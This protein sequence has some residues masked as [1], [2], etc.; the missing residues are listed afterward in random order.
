[1]TAAAVAPAAPQI[2]LPAPPP[3]P[4]AGYW[5]HL[6]HLRSPCPGCKTPF[7]G[8]AYT[9]PPVRLERAPYA[10][11]HL[12]RYEIRRPR[13]GRAHAHGWRCLRCTDSLWK[14]RHVQ[15]Q[16]AAAGALVYPKGAK[17]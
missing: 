12:F 1:M 16:L 6:S 13:R 3:P 4:P 15:Q 11:E 9:Y 14:R 8:F 5:P 7:V 17:R 2:P 10:P